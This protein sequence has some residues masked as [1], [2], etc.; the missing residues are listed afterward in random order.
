MR[1][2]FVKGTITKTTGGNHCMYS[3]GNIVTNAGGFIRETADNQI[4]YGEPED[5]PEPTAKKLINSIISGY[6]YT[7]EGVY[8]G[9]IGTGNNVYITDQATFLEVQKGKD[10]SDKITDFTLKSELNNEQFLNRAN[11]VFGEG[12]GAFADRYAMTIKNLRL[13]GRSGYGPKPFSSDEE[14][15]RMTMS[16]GN[17]PKTL[18]PDYLN[19][20]YNGSNAKA[21]A[22][23]KRNFTDLN[24]NPKM[25]IAIKG[26]IN[27]FLGDL[28]NEG[29]NNWRGSGDKLYNQDEKDKESK[30]SG[31]V[32]ESNL[33]RA[34]GK[35]YGNI[36]TKKDHYW[37]SVGIKYRRHSFI[38]ISYEKK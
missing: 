38:K 37:E 13:S 1:R 18:Y 25:N 26:V 11:W 21:F 28:I 29:Y 33:Y 4:I 7:K 19:G 16:H 8:L 5:A 34:D 14:M 15:Y 2:R 36:T 3:N 24:K 31:N 20:T 9:K 22:I 32:N 23:A 27:S 30:N 17:P 35:V 12:G 10:A 6:F